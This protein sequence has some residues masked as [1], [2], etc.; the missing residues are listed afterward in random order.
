MFRSTLF[1]LCGHQ[2][3]GAATDIPCAASGI[4]RVA[5]GFR[6]AVQFYMYIYFDVLVCKPLQLRCFTP[7]YVQSKIDALSQNDLYTTK[8]QLG[9]CEKKKEED[10]K[11][12]PADPDGGAA[13][14]PGTSS[15]RPGTRSTAEPT[16]EQLLAD[17]PVKKAMGYSE[18]IRGIVPPKYKGEEL[19][20]P[21]KDFGMAN[22][23]ILSRVTAYL[24]LNGR[25]DLMSTPRDGNCLFS[26][27][28]WGSDMPLEYVT[29]LMR[30]DLVVFVA[31][32]ADYFFNKFEDWI[33]GCYGGLRVSKEEYK[34][35]SKAGTLTDEEHRAY[36][37]P[38]PFSYQEYLQYLLKDST[39][40]D[41]VL[42]VTMSMRWQIAI[43]LVHDDLRESRVRHHRPLEKADLVLVFCG[44]YHYVGACKYFHF[45]LFVGSVA[46]NSVRPL[47]IPVLVVWLRTWSVRI[48]VVRS[49]CPREPKPLGRGT[50]S[51][52]AV[53]PPA[54]FMRPAT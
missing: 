35:K 32:N 21:A 15:S 17:G 43:T 33:K 1:T 44:N 27:V 7:G 2:Q 30:R 12:D 52:G 4:S 6:C 19:R 45:C 51:Q 29:P 36:H 9:R 13:A 8:L 42:M 40:G 10:P 24:F 47:W 37:E 26:S 53:R 50:L 49:P 54:E 25:Y 39:W 41:E 5:T 14:Q 38:G 34:E 48:S 23:K 28:K 20:G 3:Y 31:E 22:V 11:A 16:A 46:R 18:H